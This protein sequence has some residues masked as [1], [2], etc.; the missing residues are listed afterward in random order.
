M[1]SIKKLSAATAATKIEDLENSSDDSDAEQWEKADFKAGNMELVRQTLQ[2]MASRNTDEGV[3]AMWRHAR[4]IRL[5]RAFWESTPLVSHEARL[6][7]ERFFD[8]GIIPPLKDVKKAVTLAKNPLEERPAPFQGNP[9][10]LP[11]AA[12]TTIAYGQCLTAWLDRVKQEDDAPTAEQLAILYRVA[13]RVLQEFR[14]EHE[15][16]LLPKTHPE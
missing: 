7:D 12:L 6:I 3:K 11:S 8:D 15:G 14:L 2:G 1:C 5:G 9:M 16:M 10:S 13:E 4:T